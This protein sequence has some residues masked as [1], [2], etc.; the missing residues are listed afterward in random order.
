MSKWV[1]CSVN[2]ACR[3]ECHAVGLWVDMTSRHQIALT[4][5]GGEE[6]GKITGPSKG[7][8]LLF[9]QAKQNFTYNWHPPPLFTKDQDEPPYHHKTVTSSLKM[10]GCMRGE[11]MVQNSVSLDRTSQDTN[12]WGLSEVRSDISTV[13]NS[14]LKWGLIPTVPSVHQQTWGAL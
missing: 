10:W 6:G 4:A 13:Q 11:Y 8:G 3:S 1:E 14:K 9:A 12:F 7:G 5:L 2:V